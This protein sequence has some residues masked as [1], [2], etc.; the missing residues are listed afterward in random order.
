MSQL[1]ASGGQ[2]IGV[3]ASAS[4]LP[5][6]T[7]D[8]FPLGWTGWIS[9]KSK[10]LL[11]VFSNTTVQS[12][13]SLVLSFLYSPTLTSKHEVK[14][15]SRV[16]LFATPWTVA[17]QYPPSRAFSQQEYCSVLSFPSPGDLSN[18]GI[19]PRSPAFQADALTSEP[20]GKPNRDQ[21]RR[22]IKK[23]GHYFA[24]KGLS[25]QSYGF[26]RSIDVRV[27]L[28]RKLSA[29]ELMLLNC[30]VGEDSWESLGLQGESTSPSYRKS[31][32]NIHWKDWCWSWNSNTLATWCEERTHWK[33]PWC[34]ERLKAGGEGDN[35]G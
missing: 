20:P 5:M 2:S 30:G 21:P 34:W 17:Y 25:S 26:S 27:G 7:Q 16:Q 31:V 33:R 13:N 19:E 28:W 32:L 3:S 23:Q 10:G 1:F 6:N 4:V 12:I 18:P 8:W 29:E 14:P 22:C 11:T 15:L 9:L 24:N 35:R